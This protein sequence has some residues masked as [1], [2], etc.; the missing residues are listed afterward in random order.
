MTNSLR[1]SFVLKFSS[2]WKP[3]TTHFN[4]EF[5]PI[6]GTHALGRKGYILGFI[7]SPVFLLLGTKAYSLGSTYGPKSLLVRDSFVYTPG[8]IVL[9]DSAIVWGSNSGT[10]SGLISSCLKTPKAMGFRT[11]VLAHFWRLKAIA[12]SHFLF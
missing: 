9:A 4:F 1:S 8:M 10:I 6:L 11:W 5:S 12:L 2:V 3:K 7:F